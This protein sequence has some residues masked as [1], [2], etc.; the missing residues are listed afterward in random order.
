MLASHLISDVIPAIKTSD[1]GKDALHWM[2]IFR[3]SHLPVVNDKNLLGVISDNDIYDLNNPEEPIG[4]HNLNLFNPYV[5]DYQHVYEVIEMVSRL[6]LTVVPVIDRRQDFLGVITLHDLMQSFAKITAIDNRGAL[7]VLE[8]NINDYSLSE[9]SQIVESNG[10]KIVSLYVSTPQDTMKLEV[11]LKINQ[12]EAV[13]IL[14][15]FE[16]YNY[17]IKASFMDTNEMEDF[18]KDRYDSLMNFLNI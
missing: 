12:T 13:S 16:R 9:I 14:K 5:F 6:K 10:A 15:T 11:T 8:M 17:T 2:E 4:N 7:I 3:V 18:Y 1:S